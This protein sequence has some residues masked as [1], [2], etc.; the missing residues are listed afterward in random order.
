MVCLSVCSHPGALPPC[1]VL[2]REGSSNS[3][4]CWAVAVRDGSL[5]A[6]AAQ[7]VHTGMAW[8]QHVHLSLSRAL[9]VHHDSDLRSA[10]TEKEAKE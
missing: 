7:M 4:S 5:E 8:E 1:C 9:W 10:L 2:G 6:E 3:K